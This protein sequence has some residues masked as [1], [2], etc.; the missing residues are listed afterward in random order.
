MRYMYVLCT[1]K[2]NQLPKKANNKKLLFKM[3]CTVNMYM[4]GFLEIWSH[5][6]LCLLYT[7]VYFNFSNIDYIKK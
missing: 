5:F 1:I 4:Y 2:H 6:I 3:L 7:R